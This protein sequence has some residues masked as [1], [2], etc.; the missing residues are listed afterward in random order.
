[1]GILSEFKSN[2]CIVKIIYNDIGTPTSDDGVEGEGI[3]MWLTPG[4]NPWPCIVN[5]YI[6]VQTLCI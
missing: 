6:P 2:R 5:Y 1:M 3:L 4:L